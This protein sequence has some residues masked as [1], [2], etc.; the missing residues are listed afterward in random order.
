[1]A[2]F[3]DDDGEGKSTWQWSRGSSA[4]GPWTEI[5]GATSADRMPTDDDIGNWLQATVSYTDSFGAQT[6]SEEIGPVADET[7]AN[8][9]PSFEPAWTI[10]RMIEWLE[11]RLRA[12]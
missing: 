2:S 1:M 4:D 6:A 8:A 12:M 10:D 7:L 9:A 3:S 5:E 11:R